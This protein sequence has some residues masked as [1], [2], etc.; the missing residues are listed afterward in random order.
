MRSVLITKVSHT[1][2]P[3][4]NAT[5][6]HNVRWNGNFLICFHDNHKKVFDLPVF[7]TILLPQ[8]HCTSL[9]T[10]SLALVSESTVPLTFLF[11]NTGNTIHILFV[12]IRGLIFNAFCHYIFTQDRSVVDLLFKKKTFDNCNSP[13]TCSLKLRLIELKLKV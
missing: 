10:R 12:Y 11:L 2:L 3:Y 9:Q 8:L 4:S 6:A 13:S 1:F 5:A 7:P